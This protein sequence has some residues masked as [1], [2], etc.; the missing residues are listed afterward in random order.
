MNRSATSM[1]VLIITTTAVAGPTISPPPGPVTESGRFGAGS[2]IPQLPFTITASGSYYLADNLTGVVG[3]DGITID[4]DDVT[5]DFGGFALVGVPGSVQGISVA[6]AH[7]NIDIRN[8]TVRD[9]GQH[10]IMLDGGTNAIVESVRMSGNGQSGIFADDTTVIRGC[11]SV[12]NGNDGI[13]GRTIVVVDCNV[14]SNVADGIEVGVAS[15]VV[16]CVAT[17][18]GA[19]GV[20]SAV[21]STIVGCSSSKNFDGISVFPDC[22]I[23]SCTVSENTN[24]G[25]TVQDRCTVRD[26]TSV[27]N[28]AGGIGVHGGGGARIDGN[29]VAGNLR[30]IDVINTGNLIIRNSASGNGTDY[31]ILAGND[32]GPIGTA[33][34]STSP[35][36]NIAF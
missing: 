23:S 28:G 25:I 15:V 32:V 27:N 31:S 36:A 4:A 6:G 29:N 22:T 2:K 26:C 10:G 3:Q 20:A 24:A 30:G 34:T 13:V 16:N 12:S 33:A 18:N 5:I 9:W 19:R 1:L 14:D 7:I 21:R 8:G 35:W 17:N 11:V